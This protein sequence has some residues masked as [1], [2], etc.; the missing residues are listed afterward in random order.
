M[1]GL[2]TRIAA[3]SVLVIVKTKPGSI[4]KE[5]QQAEKT[6][7]FMTLAYELKVMLLIKIAK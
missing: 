5:K 2:G 7:G 1:D 6:T 3:V 4:G